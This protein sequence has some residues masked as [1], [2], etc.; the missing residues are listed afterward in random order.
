M[1]K[2][3]INCLIP[4][5][6][7]IGCGA[8]Q[9]GQRAGATD[10]LIATHETDT[11]MNMADTTMSRDT[12]VGVM[13]GGAILKPDQSLIKNLTESK[14]HTILA[15]A[16]NSAGLT[17]LLNGKG[18]FTLFAPTNAAFGKIQAAKF[19]QLMS[20][21]QRSKLKALLEAHIVAGRY[22]S[23]DLKEGLELKTI[24]GGMLKITLKD[25]NWWANSARITI[26]DIVSANGLLFVTDGIAASVK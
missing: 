15:S 3:I 18:A 21:A 20:A 25:G 7:L 9:S 14:D 26:P 6:I 19:E 17:S 5:G 23:A 4:A 1:K 13:V 11:T 10:T 12:A 2:L 8:C 24:S 22:K 16:I